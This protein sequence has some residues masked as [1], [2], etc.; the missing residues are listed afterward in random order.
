M[1]RLQKELARLAPWGW[2]PHVKQHPPGS[3]FQ[4]DFS[5]VS[6]AT[7]MLFKVKE[8]EDGERT[9][10]RAEK[11]KRPPSPEPSTPGLIT[12]GKDAIESN[13]VAWIAP[14]VAEHAEVEEGANST[15]HKPGD[16]ETLHTPDLLQA[17]RRQPIRSPVEGTSPNLATQKHGKDDCLNVQRG[18]SKLSG[19]READT[20]WQMD[21]IDLNCREQLEDVAANLLDEFD[22]AARD[23]R[24][25]S[26][27]YAT[28]QK[29]AKEG[30]SPGLHPAGSFTLPLQEIQNAR[31]CGGQLEKG[32]RMPKRSKVPTGTKP[33]STHAV[34]DIQKPKPR[35][36]KT[37]HRRVG[38]VKL[39][40]RAS[41]SLM[42][43]PQKIARPSSAV[44]SHP[45]TKQTIHAHLGK[46]NIPPKASAFTA[47]HSMS[48]AYG[49]KDTSQDKFLLEAPHK[50]YRPTPR[51][52]KLEFVEKD[53]AMLRIAK[54]LVVADGVVAAAQV[55]G[56]AF[57]KGCAVLKAMDVNDGWKY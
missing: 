31:S 29:H 14:G 51:V 17:P 41:P 1:S 42:P 33:T 13:G 34:G 16:S 30:G 40:L 37:E 20:S 49:S 27:S 35:E 2:D 18:S 5:Q 22:T 45:S 24:G 55:S 8:E 46:E 3:A 26:L 56:G 4:K 50:V 25:H 11:R 12:P 32:M 52:A 36:T 15:P 39:S 6:F 43:P 38:K 47:C 23:G 10:E 19:G 57:R 44:A 48:W 54:S 28:Q 53:T 7:E 21:P 9:G